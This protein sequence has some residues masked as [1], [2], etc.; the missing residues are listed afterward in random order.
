MYYVKYTSDFVDKFIADYEKE[1]TAYI[2]TDYNYFYIQPYRRNNRIVKHGVIF[3][4]E[5]IALCESLRELEQIKN[6]ILFL[7]NGGIKHG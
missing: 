2:D 4:G 7:I 5:Q 6:T 3:N 1:I